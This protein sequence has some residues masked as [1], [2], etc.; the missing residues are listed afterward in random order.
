M[1]VP[2]CNDINSPRRKWIEVD[3]QVLNGLFCVTGFGLAPWR[4]RDV[5]WWAWWRLGGPQRTETGIRR[6]AGIHRGWF[7]LAG[8]DQLL[9]EADATTV[10]PRDVAIPIPVQAI[11]D[12][13]PTG[14]RAPPTKTWKMDFVVWNNASNTFFQIV[15]C[16]FMYHYSRFT[17]PSWATGTFV[18]L[19]CIVAGIAGIMMWHEGKNVKKVEGV[20]TNYQE[21]SADAEAHLV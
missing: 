6:L 13:P 4:F 9:D 11:P 8:S 20:S 19:G 21:S 1:C 18:A 14:I 10:D 15:L 12:P 7:R 5:Y 2:S 3:S 16:F 17:R